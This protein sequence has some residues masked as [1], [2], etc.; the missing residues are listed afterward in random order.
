MGKSAAADLLRARGVQVLDTD[1]LARELVEPGQPSLAE[2]QAVFGAEFFGPDGRLRRDLLARRVFADPEARKQLEVILHP[3]IRKQWIEAVGVWRSRIGGQ[4]ISQKETAESRLA[5]C[6]FVVMIP[7]LFE[8]NCQQ[9]FDAT[10]CIACSA[11]TQLKRLF[12]RGWSSPQ[13]QQR[14]AAQLPIEEK[15]GRADYV[16]WSEGGLDVHATQLDRVLHR[17]SLNARE[18]NCPSALPTNGH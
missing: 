13:I 4:G 2:I 15:M 10:I 18:S 1:E 8:T 11:S 9:E 12:A 17:A 7:L 3:R 16:I 5:H 6:L 14:I